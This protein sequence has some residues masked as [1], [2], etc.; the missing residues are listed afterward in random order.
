[1]SKWPKIFLVISVTSFA[2]GLTSVGSEIAYGILK[3]IGAIMFGVFFIT[4]IL[5]KEITQYDEEMRSK[6][7]QAATNEASSARPSRT[8]VNT[9]RLSHAA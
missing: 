7:R 4:Q 2:F 9:G 6:T 3:P 5:D 1:M 8:T